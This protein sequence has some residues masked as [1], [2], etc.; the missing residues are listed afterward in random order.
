MPLAKIIAW[1][2]EPKSTEVRRASHA[3]IA[4]LFALNGPHFT[5]IL[6]KLPKIYQ[7]PL[8]YNGSS[9]L[10]TLFH[11]KLECSFLNVFLAQSNFCI[12]G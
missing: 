8:S 9:L 4:A 6:Q 2:S 5:G 3:A 10:L 1:S 12:Q 7:V 11:N